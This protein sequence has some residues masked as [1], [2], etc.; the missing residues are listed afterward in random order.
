MRRYIT[1]RV[2][3]AIVALLIAIAIAMLI[4]SAYDGDGVG[5]AGVPV[6]LVLERDQE[7]EVATYGQS[8][9]LERA[10]DW[11]E[12]PMGVAQAVPDGFRLESIRAV[13]SPK[14]LSGGSVR[15][16]DLRSSDLVY[17]HDDG[18]SISIHQWSLTVRTV[19]VPKYGWTTLD[20]VNVEAYFLQRTGA[21]SI[22]WNSPNGNLSAVYSYDDESFARGAEE[23]LVSMLKS[24]E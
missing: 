10:E 13:R 8:E 21:T 15:G 9:A 17:R 16:L 7:P 3:A 24:M 2:V 12:D 19:S 4:L 20:N 5:S 18:R 22:A 6:E 11:L 23:L 1:N 14:T